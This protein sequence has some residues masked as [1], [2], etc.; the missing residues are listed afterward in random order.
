MD[1]T[2]NDQ[3]HSMAIRSVAAEVLAGLALDLHNAGSVRLMPC[4]YADGEPTG[5]NHAEYFVGDEI[6][7]GSVTDEAIDGL[8][9]ELGVT[10]SEDSHYKGVL[11]NFRLVRFSGENDGITVFVRVRLD[12]DGSAFLAAETRCSS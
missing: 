2:L 5:E 11:E 6:P 12:A 10:F 7:V 9:G 4:Y 8:K 3:R 1:L